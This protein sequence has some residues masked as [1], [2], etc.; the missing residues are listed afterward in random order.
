MIIGIPKEHKN[1]ESRVAMAP[2]SVKK[3]MYKINL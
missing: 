2:D 1:N 3:N